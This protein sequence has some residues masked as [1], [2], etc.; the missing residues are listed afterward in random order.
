MKKTVVS[1]A[2]GLVVAGIAAMPTSA[3]EYHVDEDI[4]NSIAQLDQEEEVVEVEVEEYEVVKG[5]S[6]WRIAEMYETTVQEIIDINGLRSY[7]IHPKQV[8]Q[9]DR[10]IEEQT[11][12]VEKG[13]TLSEIAFAYDVEVEEI[14]EWNEL[15]SDLILIGQELSIHSSQT[16]PREVVVAS[17]QPEQSQE[18]ASQPEADEPAIKQTSS[19]TYTMTATAYTAECTGCSGITATGINLLED[20]DKKVIAVDPSVIPLGT[21][22]HVEGYGEA[23]AGDT[24]GA[25]KGNKIDIHVPTKEIAFNWGVRTVEVTILE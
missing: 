20:R 4:P 1:I 3:V 5:D 24:G 11:Y 7:V 12:E 14:L 21:R 6:L 10:E 16:E 23:I 2:I 13:D 25:I 19:T 22:V 15:E 8:L 9:I 17:A 18:T